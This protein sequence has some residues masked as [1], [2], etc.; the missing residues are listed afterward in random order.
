MINYECVH[1]GKAPVHAC[2][3]MGG[4]DINPS[5]L[6]QPVWSKFRINKYG[7]TRIHVIN[8]ASLN[9]QFILNENGTV[10]DDFWIT[11]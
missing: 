4:R 10:I 2:I 5:W 9:M 8:E 7:W 11:K 1:N 6:V 3:G